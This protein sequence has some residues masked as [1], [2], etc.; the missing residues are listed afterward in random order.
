MNLVEFSSLVGRIRKF[1]FSFHQTV[2]LTKVS[3]ERFEQISRSMIYEL[4]NVTHDQAVDVDD[5]LFRSLAAEEKIDFNIFNLS[6]YVNVED[7]HG[8]DADV[9]QRLSSS[10]VICGA[11]FDSSLL[12]VHRQWVAA[13]VCPPRKRVEILF[14]GCLRLWL[15]DFHVNQIRSCT[16]KTPFVV[17]TNTLDTL[18]RLFSIVT[19]SDDVVVSSL[20]SLV[21][22]SQVEDMF[23][24]DRAGDIVDFVD[25]VAV[26][27]TA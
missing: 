6:W 4:T 13:V 14:L 12:D 19:N 8:R 10:E 16:Q 3:V 15:V 18:L 17:D 2:G 5:D 22:N 20:C 26:S 23:N 11:D 1:V 9:I 21:L 24:Y 7:K 25:A 27:L